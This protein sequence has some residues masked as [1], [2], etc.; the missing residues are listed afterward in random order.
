VVGLP[1]TVSREGTTFTLSADCRLGDLV[2]KRTADPMSL[3]VRLV[4]NNYAW[5]AALTR[6][7]EQEPAIEAFYLPDGTLNIERAG[8]PA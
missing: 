5:Q 3:H 4:V 8:P 6:P 2:G 1:L 7:E